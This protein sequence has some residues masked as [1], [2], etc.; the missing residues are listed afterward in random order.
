MTTLALVC[1]A[2]SSMDRRAVADALE[3][4][5][6]TGSTLEDVVSTACDAIATGTYDRAAIV[7]TGAS[8]PA[9][10][11][12]TV[13]EPL[14]AA[15][16]DDVVWIDPRLAR[17]QSADD[18][19]RLIAAATSAAAAV[20]DATDAEGLEPA[21]DHVVVVDDP[22]LARDVAT[23]FPVT[24]VA[25]EPVGRR[26]RD[27]RTVRGRALELVEGTDGSGLSV[28]VDGDGTSER[29]A[30]DQ[31]VWPGYDGDLADRRDVHC[32]RAGVVGA[33]HR[34]AR[35]RTRE[36]VAVDAASCAVGRKGTDG[37]RACADVC[38][39]DAVAISI[40]GDGSVAIDADACTDCGACLGVCPTEA[41]ESPR[42]APLEALGEATRAAL[43]TASTEGS[44]LPL[45]GSDPDPVVIAFTA[46][47]VFPAVVAASADGP[48][49]VPIPVADASR[50]PASLCCAT[51]AA[52]AGG[53]AVVADPR[54][55]APGTVDEARRALED[56]ADDAPVRRVASTDPEAVAKTLR[57]V[58]REEPLVDD[59]DP[60]R[61]HARTATAMA[62]TAVDVLADGARQDVRV[63]SLGTVS[64]DADA[65]TLCQ[66]CSRLCPTGALAQPDTRTLT[67]DPAACVGC[68]ICVAC[69]EDAIDVDDVINVPLGD[70]SAVVESEGIVCENCG[71]PFASE[72]GF[73][74]VR[75]TLEDADLPADIG[76]ERCPSCR[77]AAGIAR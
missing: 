72:A 48:P 40:D 11:R 36:P 21:T 33:V 65:C 15:G 63:P 24:H 34:I 20:P 5:A 1:D 39:H 68:G 3:I 37:C 77:R 64:V 8:E 28:F 18:R 75:E 44:R 7:A 57:A 31:V 32:G 29:V 46:R 17:S 60:I 12:E 38:P 55:P 47:S 76:L 49:T 52:G 2:G 13:E 19:S 61:A 16:V 59:P 69:P 14:R 35:E 51:I 43:E 26:R 53:V 30:A 67:F 62:A 58:A 9:R 6:I 73:E 45:V 10:E 42:A 54:E 66:S 27:V 25:Q 23:A 4:R 70:R 50:V 71:E 56:L 74:S 22:A 41:I